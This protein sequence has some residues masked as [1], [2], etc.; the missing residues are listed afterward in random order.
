MPRRSSSS[1][2]G[3]WRSLD[4]NFPSSSPGTI[5]RGKRRPRDAV[6][7]RTFTPLLWKRPSGRERASMASCRALP[8]CSRPT[9]GSMPAV[10]AITSKERISSRAVVNAC[11][12]SEPPSSGSRRCSSR[13]AH[14]PQGSRCGQSA[15]APRRTPQARRKACAASKRFC[16]C[17][18]ESAR[19][20]GSSSSAGSED[21]V[22]SS[23][24]RFNS[25]QPFF[26]SA[27]TPR[28]QDW[29]PDRKTGSF[30]SA[31]H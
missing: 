26:I 22:G 2:K 17:A 29:T 4:G 16:A 8:I 1:R 18:T 19:F 6:T 14:S 12:S 23:S 28:F 11:Q 5:T 30:A 10:P 13:V 15:E 24:A 3:S 7:D 9:R 20:S 31:R 25:R 27:S 21:R